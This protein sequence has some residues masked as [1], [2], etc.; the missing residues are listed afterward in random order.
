MSPSNHADSLA[1]IH[2]AWLEEV[3][4]RSAELTAVE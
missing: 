3:Q 2:R 4:R 1:A